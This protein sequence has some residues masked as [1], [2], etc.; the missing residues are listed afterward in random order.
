MLKKCGSCLLP[1][2]A[3]R[4]TT[5]GKQKKKRLF[6]APLHTA[7]RRIR[8]DNKKSNDERIE[9]ANDENEI[10]KVREIDRDKKKDDGGGIRTADPLVHPHGRQES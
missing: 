10:W 9:K 8:E 2:K 5:P 7:K 6:T 1:L 3:W 4:A